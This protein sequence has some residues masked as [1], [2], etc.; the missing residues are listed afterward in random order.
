MAGPRALCFEINANLATVNDGEYH[1]L[2]FSVTGIYDS[3]RLTL[4]W[5]FR[6]RVD[7]LY[8]GE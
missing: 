6:F 7:R 3:L 4:P 5:I 2:I 1:T 8:C